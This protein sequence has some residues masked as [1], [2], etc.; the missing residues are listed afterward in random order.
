MNFFLHHSSANDLNIFVGRMRVRFCLT[1]QRIHISTLICAV[2]IVV[3]DDDDDEDE[4]YR[5]DLEI[6]EESNNE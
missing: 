4:E 1:Y 3:I 6:V 2:L 5:V